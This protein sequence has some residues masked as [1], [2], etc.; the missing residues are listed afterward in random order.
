MP[1]MG[2]V[3]VLLDG[4]AEEQ[5]H[6]KMQSHVSTTNFVIRAY[7][8]VWLLMPNLGLSLSNLHAFPNQVDHM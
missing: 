1:E 3:L 8:A 4:D 6:I 7:Q 2:F 5:V